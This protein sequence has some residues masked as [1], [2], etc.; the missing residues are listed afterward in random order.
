M[1]TETRGITERDGC[2]CLSHIAAST[3][4]MLVTSSHTRPVPSHLSTC[5]R[6]H[7]ALQWDMPCVVRMH[8]RARLFFF[9]LSFRSLSPFFLPSFF[10]TPS[11]IYTR[12]RCRRGIRMKTK[13]GWS[14]LARRQ[15]L[16]LSPAEWQVT[17]RYLSRAATRTWR[18]YACRP[19]S[20]ANSDLGN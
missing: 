19:G 17:S 2:T 14:E 11:A 15:G 4:G 18:R 3:R 5:A 20:L 6:V 1:N 9:P 7:R 12:S 10:Y 13:K 16:F 8:S